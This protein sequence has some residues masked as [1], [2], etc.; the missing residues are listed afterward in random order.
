MGYRC[1]F[2]FWVEQEK[3]FDFFAAFQKLGRMD[4]TI[5][6]WPDGRQLILGERSLPVNNPLT[7]SVE[8]EKGRF[9]WIRGRRNYG[10][11]YAHMNFEVLG[12]DMLRENESVSSEPYDYFKSASNCNFEKRFEETPKPNTWASLKSRLL[13]PELAKQYK[14]QVEQWKALRDEQADE[15]VRGWLNS[16]S[17]DVSLTLK[18]EEI[19]W[20]DG[21]P[22]CA[23]IEFSFDWEW[24]YAN[25]LPIM[26][27]RL[28][29]EGGAISL[30]Y[31]REFDDEHLLFLDGRDRDFS[32]EFPF[33]DNLA[34]RPRDWREALGELGT[35][36]DEHQAMKQL[37]EIG[38]ANR[39]EIEL[40]ATYATSHDSGLRAQALLNWK[41]VLEWLGDTTPDD[42]ARL[43]TAC[44]IALQDEDWRVRQI[45]E[46]VLKELNERQK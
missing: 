25:N 8:V 38:G 16:C 23:C 1:H 5:F 37:R 27:K 41:S 3:L 24:Q 10:F 42:W 35:P 31:D 46:K 21:E 4:S 19:T 2:H 17:F 43:E 11:L 32:F 9:E 36:S 26:F 18:P 6:V 33:F 44:Q 45:A 34:A 40:C 28:A 39:D 29:R 30:S 15:N 13:D 22:V 20:L 14:A 7:Y 12:P